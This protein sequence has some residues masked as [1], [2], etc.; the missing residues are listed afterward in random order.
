MVDI[1]EIFSKIDRVDYTEEE[2]YTDLL[3]FTKT[4]Q[5]KNTSKKD[6][7]IS[8]AT[9]RKYS[10]Y[11]DAEIQKFLDNP[12]EHEKQLRNLARYLENTSQLLANTTSYLPNIAMVCP[13][14]IPTTQK[15]TTMKLK[16][17][18]ATEYVTRLNLQKNFTQ[19]YRTC[20]REDV[21]YGLEYETDET[22]Y[23]RPLDPDYCRI[24]GIDYGSYVFQ[25]DMSF[26][27]L[28][29]EYDVNI[30]LIEEY[31]QFIPGG[32]FTNAYNNYKRNPA[33]NRWAELPGENTICIKLREDLDYN[34]P[35]FASAYKE[36][37]D[38]EDYK[39][40]GKVAEEQANYK[41][42]G[43][44]IPR[45]D[46]KADR[47]DN[48]AVKLS[49]AKLFFELAQENLSDT[50][51]M[52]YT[53]MDFQDISFSSNGTN[54]RNKVKEATEQFYD[55]LGISKLLFNSDNSTT[56]QYS[57]K[58]DES[59]IFQLN[60]QLETWITRKMIYKFKGNF[61]CIL[62]DITQL[63]K[64]A[65]SKR[66]LEGAKVGAPT[67]LLYCATLG[68]SQA[69]TMALNYLQN[70][71]LDI[72]NNYLPLLSTNTMSSTDI[73][74]KKSGRPTTD[75]PTESTIVNRDNGTNGETS[76]N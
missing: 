47:T 49:T 2:Y 24:C 57:T 23:I 63:S 52:F 74:E 53:P 46:S 33:L 62:P 13:V 67:F 41:I 71:V 31:N 34:F 27:D 32:F 19:I 75:T 72:T 6:N 14:L 68:I 56:L 8:R 42:I 58:I 11:T 39:A 66:L 51:G 12:R 10:S 59:K 48:F 64:E 37:K 55:S 4:L 29:E 15:L 30:E 38:I 40:L 76:T 1:D 60:R 35:P 65:E 17:T 36:V 50:V 26:F 25:M 73:T 16:Y 5:L 45:L 22:Y 43:F 21:F 69:D 3:N 18:E 54:A 70:E 7:W 44:K 61:R 28:Q 9:N 20:F